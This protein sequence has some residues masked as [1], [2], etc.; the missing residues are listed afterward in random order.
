MKPK[1]F[2]YTV[3]LIQ[4][5]TYLENFQVVDNNHY[6]VNSS[7]GKDVYSVIKTAQECSQR[8]NCIPQCTC[9]YLCRHV[10]TCT[11]ADYVQGHL[12]KHCNK[13]TSLINI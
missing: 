12:C 10:M 5:K 7:S 8:P 9:E 2:F 13:V 6:Q 11:C 1:L 4:Q 3:L